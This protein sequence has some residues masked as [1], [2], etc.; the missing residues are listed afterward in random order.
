MASSTPTEHDEMD[1]RQPEEV[2]LDVNQ[3]SEGYSYYYLA[4]HL[5]RP[6]PG[7]SLCCT[8]FLKGSFWMDLEVWLWSRRRRLEKQKAR[9]FGLVYN[10]MRNRLLASFR[11][12]G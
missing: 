1:E 8:L 12:A 6:P 7:I 9:L 2:L 5:V 3:L 10:K 11:S 4:E